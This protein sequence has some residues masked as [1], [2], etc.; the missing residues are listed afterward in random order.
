M[1]NKISNIFNDLPDIPHT[2]E[3][4][5]IL[6]VNNDVRIEKIVSTG[7]CSPPGFWYEQ[8]ENEFVILLKGKAELEFENE[9][10]EL[11]EGDYLNI[12]AKVKHRV[13]ST[14]DN[15]HTVWLAIFY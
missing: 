9:T 5:D 14:A 10:V 12:P 15:E 1:K 2:E 7:Q 6:A 4:V 11:N 13:K 3:L 8:K